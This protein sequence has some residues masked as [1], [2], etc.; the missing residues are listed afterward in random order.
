MRSRNELRLGQR[1]HAQA[2]NLM[3]P[4]IFG[5]QRARA[6]AINLMRRHLWRRHYLERAKRAHPNLNQGPADLQS[7]ALTTELC[8]H[9]PL[10]PSS[11]RPAPRRLSQAM[12]ARHRARPN[13]LLVAADARVQCCDGNRGAPPLLL[14]RARD[15]RASAGS[16]HAR[17]LG[18]AQAA[19][20]LSPRA[21]AWPRCATRERG[22]AGRACSRWEA[23]ASARRATSNA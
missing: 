17:A 13:A 12:R 5:G 4:A 19:R 8:T 10:M 11:F 7:A 6:Q 21:T 3:R 1:A 23:N 14:Q 18:K 20:A 16:A 2:I 15:R 22:I 9:L